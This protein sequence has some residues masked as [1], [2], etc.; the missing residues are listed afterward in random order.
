MGSPTSIRH[1]AAIRATR[2]GSVASQSAG[3]DEP[4]AKADKITIPA[5]FQVSGISVTASG[6][7][8][9]DKTQN[10]VIVTCVRS[11]YSTWAATNC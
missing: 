11:P 6:V 2:A 4:H 1:P 5:G 9:L 7:A 8:E 3:K 10:W